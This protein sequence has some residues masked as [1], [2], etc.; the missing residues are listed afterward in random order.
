MKYVSQPLINSIRREFTNRSEVL[1]RVSQ[2]SWFALLGPSKGL[3]CKHS[4]CSYP[5][6][7]CSISVAM[8]T[9]LGVKYSSICLLRHTGQPCERDNNTLGWWCVLLFTVRYLRVTI[10]VICQCHKTLKHVA[11]NHQKVIQYAWGDGV[12]PQW[13]DLCKLKIFSALFN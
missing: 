11:F 6:V 4:P 7:V 12:G 8:D 1:V 13:R 3:H 10:P 9:R 5:I 2:V